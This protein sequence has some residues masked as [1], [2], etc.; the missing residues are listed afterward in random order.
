MREPE[1]ARGGGAAGHRGLEATP[2]GRGAATTPQ[3]RG[4][5][6]RAVVK[7]QPPHPRDQRAPGAAPRTSLGAR[8]TQRTLS[9]LRLRGLSH[10]AP[11]HVPVSGSLGTGGRPGQAGGRATAL[12][13][14][15][16]VKSGQRQERRARGQASTE[17]ATAGKREKGTSQ[18][19]TPG[20]KHTI[21][22]TDDVVQSCTLETYNF[23]N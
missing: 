8:S 22:C 3:R 7:C 18:D 15:F 5:P 6:P 16:Q 4:T 10:P 11:G 2:C 1:P 9:Q 19:W 21:Q 13:T 17:A 12:T 23:I 20:G 14:R